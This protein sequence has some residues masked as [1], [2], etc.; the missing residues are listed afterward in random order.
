ME[1][2][3]RTSHSLVAYRESVVL[4]GGAGEFV[5]SC[6]LR[7][8]F[9]DLWIFNTKKSNKEWRRVNDEGFVPKKRMQHAA[10]VIGGVMLISAGYNTEARVVMDDFC[11]FDFRLGAWIPCE[12]SKSNGKKFT[13]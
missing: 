7:K 11:M 6:S 1:P 9:N 4:F 5:K 12:M 13:A 8:G 3:A 2:D 10:G